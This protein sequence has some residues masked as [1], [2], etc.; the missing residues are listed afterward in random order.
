MKAHFNVKLFKTKNERSIL[1]SIEVVVKAAVVYYLS[2]Q[3]VSVF[4]KFNTVEELLGE[5]PSFLLEDIDSTE[6]Q[7]MLTY[8]N[9]MKLALEVIPAK[10]NKRL[11][12]NICATLEGSGKTYITG[13]TQSLSTFRRVQ[14]YE[15]ESEIIPKKRPERRVVC[16][17]KPSKTGG[18]TTCECGSVILLRTVWRHKKSKRHMAYL[19]KY[20]I[21]YPDPLEEMYRSSTFPNGI[22]HF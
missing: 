14:I 13:G 2:V 16:P 21:V 17:I 19:E 15:H 8:R 18:T 6:L 3:Q 22:Q 12:M 20:G 5:Y 1:F 9:M 4:D 10:C 7:Y 11:L